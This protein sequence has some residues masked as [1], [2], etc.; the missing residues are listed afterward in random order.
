MKKAHNEY[1]SGTSYNMLVKTVNCLRPVNR[2]SGLCAASYPR[3]WRVPN[4]VTTGGSHQSALIY[5]PPLHSTVRKA[6]TV[7]LVW[8]VFVQAIAGTIQEGHYTVFMANRSRRK[9]IQIQFSRPQTMMT[10]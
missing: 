10:K 1:Q 4:P 6:E 8:T 5:F 3:L 7:S 2:Q 9:R